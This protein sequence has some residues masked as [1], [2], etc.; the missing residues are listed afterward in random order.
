MKI[1]CSF[2]FSVA[3]SATTPAHAT[4]ATTA[5]PAV[6]V[7]TTTAAPAVVDGNAPD[8]NADAHADHSRDHSADLSFDYPTIYYIKTFEFDVIPLP[9]RDPH[10]HDPVTT[11]SHAATTA[12]AH[13]RVLGGLT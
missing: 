12:D 1:I 7:V 10:A 11:D 4:T 13:H 6:V 9:Y 5:A 3:Y 2:L 8:L